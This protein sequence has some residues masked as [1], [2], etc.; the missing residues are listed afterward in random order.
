MEKLGVFFSGILIRTAYSVFFYVFILSFVSGQVQNGCLNA[1][2]GV[3]ADTRGGIYTFGS[4]SQPGADT[5]DWFDGTTGYGVVD[6][7]QKASVE[8][9]LAL[10]NNIAINLGQS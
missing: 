4:P 9:Q 10:G 2:F 3:D 6:T 7:S 5:D 1:N 8:S